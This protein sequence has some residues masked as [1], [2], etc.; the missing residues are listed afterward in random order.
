MVT[1]DE[2]YSVVT[3]SLRHLMSLIGSNGKFVYAHRLNA[4]HEHLPGYNILRHCGTVWFMCKAVAE[5]K[6]ELPLEDLERIRRAVAY[7]RQ[8]LVEP[9]WN[10]GV[11][12]SLC[13]P[14][15]GNVKIGA[16]GLAL[17]MLHEFD[18]TLR[19]RSA[20]DVELAAL[21]LEIARLENYII[22]QAASRDFVHKRA[23]ADGSIA[24]FQSE[25]YTGEVLFGLARGKRFPP[26][27]SQLFFAL[28]SEGYGLDIQSHWMCYATCEAVEH[29]LAENRA[30]ANYISRLVQAIIDGPAYRERNQSTPI[31]CRTEALTRFLLLHKRTQLTSY[32]FAPQLVKA[33]RQAVEEN[34]AL[35]LGW[36]SNGQFHKGTG[37]DKV[38]IDY[39]QHN[40]MA[41]LMWYLL[42]G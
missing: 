33:A 38:Q 19:K 29:Q 24:S 1:S 4:A 27:I 6:L 34:L 21:T 20:E 17:L 32:S 42:A 25:Y 28:I 15:K 31:A 23:L 22:G 13:L 40:A 3:A 5:L 7:V 39:L 8:R 9:K 35:Q 11:L 12:P 26:E 18:A 30:V 2:S 37:D 16:N 36:Y 14:E 10:E 41:F